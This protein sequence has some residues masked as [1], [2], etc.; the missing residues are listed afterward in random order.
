MAT[1]LETPFKGESS[2]GYSG[3]TQPLPVEDTPLTKI[4]RSLTKQNIGHS[5][6]KTPSFAI[7]PGGNSTPSKGFEILTPNSGNYSRPTDYSS[8]S[9]YY[10]PDESGDVYDSSNAVVR[11][12]RTESETEMK[13]S[14]LAVEKNVEDPSIISTSLKT[15]EKDNQNQEMITTKAVDGIGNNQMNV[16]SSSSSSSTSN[17]SSS[18][19]ASSM[20]ESNDNDNKITNKSHDKSRSNEENIPVQ[21]KTSNLTNKPADKQPSTTSRYPIRTGKIPKKLEPFVVD[22]KKA[23]D[24]Q[25]LEKKRLRVQEKINKTEV[26]QKKTVNTRKLLMKEIIAK[27][28][29]V[30]TNEINSKLS[31]S[32]SFK[33]KKLRK[34]PSPVKFITKQNKHYAQSEMIIKENSKK[35]NVSDDNDASELISIL[36]DKKDGDSPKKFSK[37]NDSSD[38]SCIPKTVEKNR[39]SKEKETVATNESPDLS[40]KMRTRSS[41]RNEKVTPVKDFDQK[42]ESISETKKVYNEEQLLENLAQS[43]IQITL[44]STPISQVADVTEF[45]KTIEK[46]DNS[47]I[48]SSEDDYDDD[49]DDFEIES[50]DTVINIEYNEKTDVSAPIQCEPFDPEKNILN[51]HLDSKIIVLKVH[52]TVNLYESKPISC[53]ADKIKR[54]RTAENSS[55]KDNKH[56]RSS[57]AQNSRTKSHQTSLE[58]KTIPKVIQLNVR[59]DKKRSHTPEKNRSHITTETTKS[60]QSKSTED[61]TH[62][63]KETIE[64]QFKSENI[65]IV[66]NMCSSVP[67]FN[68]KHSSKSMERVDAKHE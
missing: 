19:S 53:K 50:I 22:E 27:R 24:Q 11:K 2:L 47:V 7:T 58:N 9:S 49:D 60:K 61:K 56:S 41:S 44:T 30:P 16:S 15:I 20:N 5:D 32:N 3:F 12:F 62:V 52:P 37:T 42:S 4:L 63:K 8:S 65:D 46:D 34:N 38:I 26:I 28:N 1:L 10:R 59:D 51:V 17:Y 35:F 45:K 33:S 31:V 48:D 64:K 68:I 54:P 23:R 66:S 55:S 40:H 14:F 25:E 43:K 29:N 39:F 36:Q 57:A 13:T 6:I 18:S 21:N 67:I